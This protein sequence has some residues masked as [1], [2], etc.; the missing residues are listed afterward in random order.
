MQEI[1]GRRVNYIK[2][3]L[4]ELKTSIDK[5]RG[6]SELLNLEISNYAN[7]IKELKET[8]EDCGKSIEVLD[9]AQRAITDDMKEGFESIVTYALQYILGEE[10]SFQL[11]FGRR[12]YLQEMDFNIISPSLDSS[13]DPIDSSGGGTLD[14][15]SLALRVSILELQKPKNMGIL[16]I[17]EPFKHLSRK[18]LE[19]AGRFLKAVSEKIGRQVI[20]V[21]HK[22][23]LVET[24][25]KAIKIG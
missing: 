17:D 20:M 16:A 9:L 7:D 18:Y 3:E 1:I 13:S 5:Q 22:N 24:S 21:T 15:V 10:Y 4:S 11:T 12:G 23:E 2:S 14:V 6:E 19:S 8:S 25:D